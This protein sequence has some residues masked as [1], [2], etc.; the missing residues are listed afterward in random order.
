MWGNSNYYLELAVKGLAALGGAVVGGLALGLVA[1]V[2]AFWL[3]PRGV[4]APV[5]RAVRLLGGVLAGIGV[6]LL[7]TAPGGSGLFG[8][9]GSWFGGLGSGPGAST[10][11][12]APKPTAKQLPPPATSQADPAGRDTVRVVLLGGSRVTGERF[13]R[14]DSD[15]DP[16]TLVELKRAIKGRTPPAKG[17]EIVVYENSVAKDHPA[18]KDLQAWAV[19]QN[20]D[21][22]LSF[23]QGDV[24]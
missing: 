12:T 2:L 5:M 14:L 24:P 3:S 22:K 17:V 16:V 13:Y 19:G 18:V 9:G 10:E 23:P 20:L 4:P 6:W 15:P 21:V 8:G 1:R 7:L 11:T